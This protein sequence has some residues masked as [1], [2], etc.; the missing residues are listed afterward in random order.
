[1]K[2]KINKIAVLG[3]GVMGTRIALH[4]ANVG[5]KVYLLDIAPKELIEIEKQKGLSI[6]SPKVK[7]RIVNENFINILKAK[8]SPV[9]NNKVSSFVT[10]GNFDDN[11]NWLGEVDW[12][13]EV[14]VEN[15]DI[16]KTVFEKVEKFR[17]TGTLITTNT[18]GIPIHF[19]IE[20][21]KIF[22]EHIFSIP[23]DIYN[24]LRL[25]HRLKRI[26]IL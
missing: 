19:M 14:V 20:G 3:S 16:K 25:S 5:C 17:K 26:L 7:N 13:I 6:D 4:F 12:I 24:Y 2:R 15:L 11:M 1:M 22:A 18:S 10:T 23:Q 21:K 8:P 9:Y